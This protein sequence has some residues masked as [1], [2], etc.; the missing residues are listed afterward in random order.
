MLLRLNKQ[1]D[2]FIVFKNYRPMASTH[3]LVIP[4]VH[5]GRFILDCDACVFSVLTQEILKIHNAECVKSLGRE[6]VE[7]GECISPDMRE[8]RRAYA[9]YHEQSVR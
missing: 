2:R 5:I 3:L 4:R 7:L 9:V 8:K 1:N 6:D